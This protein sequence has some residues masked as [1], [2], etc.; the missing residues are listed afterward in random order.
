MT[1]DSDQNILKSFD[2]TFVKLLFVVAT[3]ASVSNID[4]YA[5]CCSCQVADTTEIVTYRCMVQYATIL[6]LFLSD[7]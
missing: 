2:L 7:H 5:N 3:S 1:L 4:I 6:S